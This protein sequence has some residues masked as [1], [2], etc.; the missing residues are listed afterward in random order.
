MQSNY[1]NSHKKYIAKQKMHHITIISLRIFL[2]V[3]FI[4]LWEITT[5]TGLIDSFIFSSPGR[6]IKCFVKLSEDGMIY[7][8][9]WITIYET[10]ICFAIV[11]GVAFFTASLMWWCR[12]IFEV[13]EPFLVLLN[14]LPKSALA[15]VLIVWLGNDVKTII[16]AAVS[17]AVF[18]AILSMYTGFI[19]TDTE[20]IKLIQTL[21]GTK[22]HIL[23]LLVIPS[24]LPVIINTMKVNLGLSLV[25]VIIGEFLAA[26][27]GLGYLIIYGSQVF[28]MDWV[29]L[30]IVILALLSILLYLIIRLIEKKLVT[31]K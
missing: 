28:K 1:S 9:M 12:G 31:S 6:M 8:H 24:S 23:F 11:I 2:A 10:L 19:E 22:K 29:L 25:G 26:K 17:V 14:S 27:E 3:A 13:L 30:S 20:K 4:A 18:G 7:R 5:R 15:P 21:G 16:V